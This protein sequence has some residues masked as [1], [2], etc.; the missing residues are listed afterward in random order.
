MPLQQPARVRSCPSTP[1]KVHLRV[2]IWLRRGKRSIAVNLKKKEG[3]RVVRRVCQHVRIPP[4]NA[5]L[6][7][8]AVCI[9]SATSDVA[10]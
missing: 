3:Q 5:P 10:R 7:V 6:R 1:A 9:L 4:K 2:R 8:R